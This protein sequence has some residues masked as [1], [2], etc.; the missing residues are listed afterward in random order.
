ME[1]DTRARSPIEKNTNAMH[2]AHN[3]NATNVDLPA[4]TYTLRHT[5][6]HVTVRLSYRTRSMRVP[7]DRL[8]HC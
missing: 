3:E 1:R 4:F 2:R 8:P 5:H 7:D 6:T